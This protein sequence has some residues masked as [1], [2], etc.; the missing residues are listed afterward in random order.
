MDQPLYGFDLMRMVQGLQRLRDYH[1]QVMF[2]HGRGE[3]TSPEALQQWAA[4]LR[5]HRLQP[6]S[7][8]LYTVDRHPAY[9]DVKPLTR[10][11]L[12]AVAEQLRRLVPFP[13]EVY[14]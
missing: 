1:F 4:F 14:V 12:E 3:N 13:V 11:E 7:I 10:A 2:L 6:R 9:P 5:E 8:Q